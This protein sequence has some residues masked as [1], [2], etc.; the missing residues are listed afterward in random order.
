MQ[1]ILEIINSNWDVV[2]TA[3]LTAF[4]T[5]LGS[6]YKFRR[7]EKKEKLNRERDFVDQY[8][9]IISEKQVKNTNSMREF[10]ETIPE[11]DDEFDFK[12]YWSDKHLWPTTEEAVLYKKSD[13]CNELV[14]LL[15]MAFEEFEDEQ[16]QL[17]LESGMTCLEV[18]NEYL[19][20]FGVFTD[21]E[22]LRNEIIRKFYQDNF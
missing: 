3:V 17:K 5:G 12:N 1:N 18:R 10:V 4:A 8:L 13:K 2:V 14:T 6:L 20:W 19:R 7:D 9:K 11:S 15:N 22:T 21:H 16:T